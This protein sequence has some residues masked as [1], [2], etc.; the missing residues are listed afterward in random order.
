MRGFSGSVLGGVERE[1]LEDE[2]SCGAPPEPEPIP[3]AAT[4]PPG[5]GG[6]G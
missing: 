6:V 2:L 5:T 4:D 3:A 1:R